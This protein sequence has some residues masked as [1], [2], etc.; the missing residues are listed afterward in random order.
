MI[1]TEER[2]PAKVQTFSSVAALP[3]AGS[4]GV[5]T[6]LVGNEVYV[7]DGVTWSLDIATTPTRTWV[8]AQ[9]Q[10]AAL[11]GRRVHITDVGQ[12]A[13]VW[14]SNGTKLIHEGPISLFVGGGYLLPGL[15]ASSTVAQVGTTVT[16]TNGAAVA[17]NIPATTYDGYQVYFPG[18]AAIPAGWYAGFART[19][20]TAYTF[21]RATATVESEAVNEESAYLT[22]TTVATSTILGNLLGA[23]GKIKV[24]ALVSNI[25]SAG[26]K[27]V[28]LVLGETNIMTSVQTTVEYLDFGRRIVNKTAAKQITA[29]AAAT[30]HAS[31]AVAPIRSAVDTTAGVPVI[32]TLQLETATD[33]VALDEYRIEIQPS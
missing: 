31:L 10:V 30:N 33:Y 22:E 13:S 7:S 20:T 23:T 17:H 18:S 24:E 19:S 1:G 15:S 14:Y 8:Q 11:E 9:A 25:N 26:D 16:V 27:T 29:S 3:N 4:F 28:K 21:T 6:A 2:T 5:G 32:F 12:N